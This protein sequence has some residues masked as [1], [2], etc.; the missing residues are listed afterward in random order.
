MC[1]NYNKYTG[2]FPMK[3]SRDSFV[4]GLLPQEDEKLEAYQKRIIEFY[5]KADPETAE[6]VFSSAQLIVTKFTVKVQDIKVENES[7]ITALLKKALSNKT[8]EQLLEY[9]L[10]NIHY[11]NTLYATISDRALHSIFL[12][13][14][15]TSIEFKKQFLESPAS[16]QIENVLVEYCAEHPKDTK[17]QE[18]LVDYQR[19][20]NTPEFKQKQ[21]L[22]FLDRLREMYGFP[23]YPEPLDKFQQD[24]I[25][26]ALF[27]SDGQRVA[28]RLK[29]LE[30]L[31]EK[32]AIAES[33]IAPRDEKVDQKMHLV[34]YKEGEPYKD[35]KLLSSVLYAL[36]AK[37]GFVERVKV[38]EELSK[39]EFYKM[40]KDKRLFKDV[41]FGGDF[42]GEW[43]HFIQWMCIV[44]E[45]AEKGFL[46][47]SS[48]DVY[49]WMETQRGKGFWN[50]TFETP[51]SSF[52]SPK[53]GLDA[54]LVAEF[55]IYLRGPESAV[56]YPLLQQLLQG[57]ALKRQQQ[58]S[59]STTVSLLKELCE[60]HPDSREVKDLEA[61]LDMK[62][63]SKKPVKST[64]LLRMF[65][66][67]FQEDKSKYP[68][69]F[70]EEVVQQ[71][72]S[73]GKPKS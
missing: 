23:K 11:T 34:N 15:K 24:L 35:S 12:D 32:K 42:H 57:R 50:N 29:E 69:T 5:Q 51:P 52:F 41:A 33:R 62:D 48:A 18:I 3:S 61:I 1:Y 45:Q 6:R 16:Y 36:A 40:F 7:V 43:T 56:L 13:R 30:E 21:N 68:S 53:G 8:P 20:Q 37:V 49:Q 60:K 70:V 64:K 22:Y 46:S 59:N 10:A 27:L 17:M 14:L 66:E 67:R 63:E 44:L 2:G 19:T 71:L 31:I 28:K 25:N 54:R 39:E 4:K 47:N 72:P 73:L 9:F 38:T 65:D 26:I 55:D 58:Q